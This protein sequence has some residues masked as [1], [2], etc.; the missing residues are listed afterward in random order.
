M[1]AFRKHN[2]NVSS[3]KQSENVCIQVRGFL[4]C[5]L[6]KKHLKLG[7][8]FYFLLNIIKIVL[9]LCKLHYSLS[10]CGCNTMT[11]ADAL[12]FW[13]LPLPW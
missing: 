9:K 11:I 7:H 10:I 13:K 4:A 5:D 8:D 12:L 1:C 2:P 6:T 3:L